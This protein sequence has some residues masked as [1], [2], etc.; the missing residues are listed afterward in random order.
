MGKR[1]GLELYGIIGHP[2]AHSLSPVMHNAAFRALGIDAVYVPFDVVDVEGAMRG[3]R[4]LGIKGL[5]VTV[6]HKE[7]VM[8]YL[9]HVDALSRRIGAVNT[10]INRDGRLEGTNTDWMGAVRA[11]EEV[12]PLAGKNALVVGAGGAARAIVMGLLERGAK[13][14]IAN[15]T[16]KRARRLATSFG[17][18][19]SGLKIPDDISFDILI[20]ATTI[21]MNDD[22]RL[23]VDTDVIEK[24][25]VV[26]DIVYSP[27]KTALL[28]VASS[29]GKTTINGLKMLLYQAISQFE[30]WTGRGAPEKIMEGALYEGLK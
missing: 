23:P 30:L 15:R 8:D 19:Y 22:K 13:V 18:S 25:D 24:T 17:C 5:S 2:V 29:M 20:N 27:L 9:D 28:K 6:P 21:G 1:K 14:H 3:V 7:A 4:A 11:I 16:E 10:V 26:M 12:C